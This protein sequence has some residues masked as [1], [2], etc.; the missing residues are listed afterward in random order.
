VL[1]GEYL[2]ED[3]LQLSGIQ[4]FIFCRRQWALI[5]IER[6]WRDNDLTLEGDYLHERAHDPDLDGMAKGVF[7]SRAMPVHSRRLGLSGACDVVEFHPDESGI[8]LAGKRGLFR[9]LPVEY[10]RGRSKANDCDRAQLCAQAMCLEEMLGIA[11]PQGAIYYAQTRR[12]EIVQFT[13]ELRGLVER[14]AH[15]MHS[16]MQKEHT[17]RVKRSKSCEACSLKDCCLP[18]LEKVPEVSRYL[19]EKLKALDEMDPDFPPHAA[20]ES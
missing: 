2:E 8:S 1:K 6:L 11:I 4:H 20:R 15:E 18:S 19:S 13:P 16:L 5:T 17:P 14:S 12:R 10:K 7:L 3:Y 9:P